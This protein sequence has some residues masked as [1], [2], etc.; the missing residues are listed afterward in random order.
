MRSNFSA[1]AAA[2]VFFAL[3]ASVQAGARNLTSHRAIYDLELAD[4]AGIKAPASASGRIVYEFSS[5]CE[6]YAQ[7][8]RQVL[9]LEPAEGERQTTETRTTTF[10][11]TTGADFRFNIAGVKGGGQEVDGHA[12]RDARGVSIAL[13]RPEPYRLKTEPDVI[14]PTQHVAK[15]IEAARRGEK[16][17]L[18]R[19][20]DGSEDGRKIF[21]VTTIIG[22]PEQGPDPDKGARAPALRGLK[23]WPV[24]VAYFPPERRDGAPDY[25]LSFKLYENGVSSGLKLDYGDFVL[26]G[27]LVRI[28]FPRAAKCGR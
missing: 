25:V 21:D 10:E 2:C 5:A 13:T 9:D 28:E 8:L 6:G 23:R 7:T 27:E 1:F 16:V 18:A 4:N 20:Y 3:P 22:K 14:F 15:I 26:K 24:A 19:V 17:F 11:D 12:A